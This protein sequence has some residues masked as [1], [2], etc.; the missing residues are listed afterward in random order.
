[1]VKATQ[2]YRDENLS[3]RG[4]VKK[5]NDIHQLTALLEE[6]DS[7]GRVLAEQ[8]FPASGPADG[9]GVSVAAKNGDILAAFQHK[10]LSEKPGG[11][12]SSVRI[13]Q[14]LDPGMLAAVKKLSAATKLN[15]VAMFEFRQ[16]RE[17]KQWILLEVNARP[18]GS[19]PLPLALNLDFP[20]MMLDIFCGKK[21]IYPT[22]YRYDVVGNNFMLGIMH[23]LG[24]HNSSKAKRLVDGLKQFVL[25]PV[26]GL[27]GLEKLDS[28]VR[29]DLAPGFWEIFFVARKGFWRLHWHR[30]GKPERRKENVGDRTTIKRVA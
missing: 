3:D 14:P 26:R 4:E 1:M 17:T 23:A 11:G 13:S 18:W 22:S 27:L 5:A 20:R 28:F 7:S 24:Q 30:V 9:I 29:D 19:M 25:T 16:C 15:G 8:F 12:S 6:F 2:S 21:I 10:R